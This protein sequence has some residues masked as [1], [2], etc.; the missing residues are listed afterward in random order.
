MKADDVKALAMLAA[1]VGVGYVGWKAWRTGAD[2]AGAVSD[3]ADY[4]GN[5]VSGTWDAV[6]GALGKGATAVADAA[7]SAG[8]AVISAPANV[9]RKAQN[10]VVAGW[11]FEYGPM[12]Q[13]VEADQG[14]GRLVRV[15]EGWR[16]YDSGYAKGPD[17]TIYFNGQRL[18]GSAGASGSW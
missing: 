11:E 5:A 18:T 17:G 4:I 1:V 9:L 7:K 2:A 3:A 13:G 16:Y 14:F 10:A 8:Q 12:V 15:W 6:T